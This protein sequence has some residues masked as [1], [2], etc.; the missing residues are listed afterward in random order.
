MILNQG[1]VT[2]LVPGIAPSRIVAQLA[3][4]SEGLEET[5]M[6]P[7]AR[8]FLSVRRPT[9][10]GFA[11][12]EFGSLRDDDSRAATM[13]VSRTSAQLL[14]Q[15]LP[16]FAASRIDPSDCLTPMNFARCIRNSSTPNKAP[17]P[18]TT[19]VTPRAISPVFEMKLPT[20]KPNV[21]PVAPAAVVA[22]L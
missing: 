19:A 17:E 10:P 4:D 12:S 14:S 11:S 7:V 21:A 18:T 1:R 16:E 15:A 9:P 22:H 5:M 6:N 20:P 8:G 13:A 2:S 3:R